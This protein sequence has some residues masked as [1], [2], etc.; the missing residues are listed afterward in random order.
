MEKIIYIFQ[1]YSNYEQIW[2]K[3][4]HTISQSKDKFKSLSC[5][6]IVLILLKIKKYMKL[7]QEILLKQKYNKIKYVIMKNRA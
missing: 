4:K 2:E 6:F 1:N 7:L 3:K 5:F